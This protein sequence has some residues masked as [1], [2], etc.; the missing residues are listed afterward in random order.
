MVETAQQAGPIDGAFDF[1]AFLLQAGLIIAVA[2]GLAL[3]AEL[4]LGGTGTF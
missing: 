4:A 1:S 2:L 3:G